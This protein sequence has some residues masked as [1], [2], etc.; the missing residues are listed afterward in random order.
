MMCCVSSIA[1]FTAE[2]D[3]LTDVLEDILKSF[4]EVLTAFGNQ[5]GVQ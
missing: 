1:S 5:K 4:E 2:S 3:V